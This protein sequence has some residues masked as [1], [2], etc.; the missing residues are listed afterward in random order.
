MRDKMKGK[1]K[2]DKK[3]KR[4]TAKTG[5]KTMTLP[6]VRYWQRLTGCMFWSCFLFLPAR[7]VSEKEHVWPCV[8]P[9]TLPREGERG[10][11]GHARSNRNSDA[12]ANE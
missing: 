10:E 6:V 5:D 7:M 9:A 11:I 1:R 2:Q 12:D 3:T 4:K 8:T